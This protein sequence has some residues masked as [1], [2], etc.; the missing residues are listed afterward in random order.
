MRLI[1]K[2]VEFF[3]FTIDGLEFKLVQFIKI[4]LFIFFDL[5]CWSN[6]YDRSSLGFLLLFVW[7][8]D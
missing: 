4:S 3:D 6:V 2:F 5:Y 7:G 1:K 8:R